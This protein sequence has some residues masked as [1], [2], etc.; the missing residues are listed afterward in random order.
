V[1]ADG[2]GDR[3]GALSAD[4]IVSGADDLSPQI[5][6]LLSALR[7]I[8]HV[9]YLSP[10][11]LLAASVGDSTLPVENAVAIVVALADLDATSSE[12]LRKVIANTRL[13]LLVVLTA[14]SAERSVMRE[15]ASE[16]GAIDCLLRDELSTPLLEAAISHARSVNRQ[17]GRLLEVRQRFALAI[18]GSRDGMWEWDL[19]RERVYY[20]QRW[21][22][23][24]GVRSSEVA[25]T[26]EGWLSRVHPQDLEHL[27]SEL[28]A[29]IEGT[30]TLHESEHRI[31]DGSDE[32]RWVMTRAVL[33]R[34]PSG[35][36]LRMAGSLTDI[37]PFRQRERALREQSRHD[38]LTK[39][40][41]RRVFLERCAR[42]VELSRAHDD[43][44]FVVLLVAVDRLAQTRDSFGIDAA[45]QLFALLAK[46]VR[47][48]LRPEDHLFRFSSSKF[49]ILLEDAEDASFGTQVANRIHETVVEPFEFDG[50]STF[51]TVSIG[52][53]S[54][55]HGYTRV[56]D[57][58]TDVSA[59]TD[60]ARDH[61]SNRHEIYDTRMRIESRT[62]LALEMAMRR[63]IDDSQFEL[64]F[65]P[66]VR[67][68]RLAVLRGFTPDALLGFEALL[69]W[70]HPERGF[71]MPAEFIPI[72][73]DT[74]LI[75]PIGRWVIREAVRSLHAWHEEFGNRELVVSVN[76]SVKQIGDPLLLETLD[77]VLSETGLPPSCLKLELTESVML[78]RIE[79]VTALLQ[80]IRSR[81]IQI[82]IDD[83]GTGYSSLGYLHRF[84][85]DGL[86][87]DR[88]FVSRLDGTPESQ[89][90]VRTILDLASNF[91][92][93]V[94]AEGIESDVQARHLRDLGC[95][96]CQGWLFGKAQP[97]AQ[98]RMLLS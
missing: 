17:T 43:Y 14:H 37:S 22:E 19:L 97:P 51:T 68:D 24:L 34:N 75:V 13:P 12:W 16:A 8:V 36:V 93:D 45:D 48:C 95:M 64:H 63:A 3:G 56:E 78:D 31:R 47:A 61:G 32:W 70:Q 21:C 69:R 76:L 40:P 30:A 49:A 44:V 26:L 94:V 46:R 5:A 74:G 80:A 66:I 50:V 59:A 11:Q 38:T 20:S 35:K 52:M 60:S 79:E 83:F 65:Q 77:M 92:L 33:H 27:R 15:R 96:V 57:V 42:A 91:G 25:P 67:V 84:P 71:V 18:Q 55:A 88:A 39:L 6:A 4:L 89:T 86:K 90:M 87:I 98:V 28:D 62:L 29:V 41:D 73:E 72:A 9:R 7:P 81:G 23:L 58:V 2:V 10:A 54:S 85:V 53:T 82:W 1:E